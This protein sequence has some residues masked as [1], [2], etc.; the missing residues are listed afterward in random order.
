MLIS[1]G[2]NY[3]SN[4]SS[5]SGVGSGT[6]GGGSGVNSTE[7]EG[8]YSGMASSGYTFWM[9]ILPNN[10][11][12]GVYGTVHGNQVLLDGMITGQ[13]ATNS[14]GYTAGVTDFFYTGQMA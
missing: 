12:Y 1:C 4:V 11:L 5:G 8:V 3:N 6:A 9:I 14:S 10:K 7:D 2:A 13:G